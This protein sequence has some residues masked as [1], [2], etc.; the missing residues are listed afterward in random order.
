[1]SPTL[2]LVA[3]LLCYWLFA[4]TSPCVHAVIDQQASYTVGFEWELRDTGLYYLCTDTPPD[5]L[6][7]LGHLS[8]YE[9]AIPHWNTAATHLQIRR[10][11]WIFGG[12]STLE[13]VT[14]PYDVGIDATGA[15]TGL[16]DV[17]REVTELTNFLRG[18]TP[19]RTC[20][21]MLIC[22]ASLVDPGKVS[23]SKHE[24]SVRPSD[25]KGRLGTAAVG[26]PRTYA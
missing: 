7:H 2:R 20:A 5:C 25:V 4:S 11:N 14:R 10:D 6:Y 3:A 24:I 13:V 22:P 19:G 8:K 21:T 17:A 26:P 18:T 1:M 9:D 16:D 12:A 23:Q 15:I